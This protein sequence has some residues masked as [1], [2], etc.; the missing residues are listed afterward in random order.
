VILQS[1]SVACLDLQTC[2][3]YGS[4]A[5][6]KALRCCLRLSRLKLE[7]ADMG[8]LIQRKAWHRLSLAESAD[9]NMEQ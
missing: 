2:L 4:D 9:G 3:T 6:G 1:V 7:L 8:A 5:I